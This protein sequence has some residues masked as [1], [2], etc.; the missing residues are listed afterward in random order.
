VLLKAADVFKVGVAGAPV[1]HWDGYDTH[2]TSATCARRRPTRRATRGQRHGARR[3]VRGKLLLVQ[4]W[5]TRTHFRHTTRLIQ[6][7][8]AGRPYDLLAYPEE[9]HMPRAEKTAGDMESGSGS[10]S[11]GT[12]DPDV[13]RGWCPIFPA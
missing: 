1:T 8:P 4:G 6:A 11:S 12:F 2:Y 13:R 7:L 3:Q 10:T 5:S 9:R